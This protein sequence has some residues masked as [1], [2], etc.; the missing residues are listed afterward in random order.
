MIRLKSVAGTIIYDRDY[1][2]TDLL[3]P[4]QHAIIYSKKQT[5]DISRF[6]ANR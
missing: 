5:V 2:F 3:C 4:G 6:S 1:S